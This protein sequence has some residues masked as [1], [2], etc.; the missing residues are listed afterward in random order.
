MSVTSSS[1]SAQ[2]HIS[3]VGK[4]SMVNESG[5]NSVW[6]LAPPSKHWRRR[7]ASQRIHHS[8][9]RRHTV[10]TAPSF[11]ESWQHQQQ[12]AILAD[13][14]TYP[15]VRTVSFAPARHYPPQ[16]MSLSASFAICRLA[17]CRSNLSFWLARSSNVNHSHF[18]SLLPAVCL[19]ASITVSLRL[20]ACAHSPSS[21]RTNIYPKL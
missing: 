14:C 8:P 15:Q 1:P 17:L 20:F 9:G 5:D 7:S 3:S 6:Q 16:L 12:P 13:Q 18:F 4:L 2:H 21:I 11:T 10:T 19:W